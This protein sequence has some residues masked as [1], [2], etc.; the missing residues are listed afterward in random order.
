M[1]SRM[2]SSAVMRLR[3]LALDPAPNPD[4]TRIRQEQE[5]IA[6]RLALLDLDLGT[7]KEARHVDT[8]HRHHA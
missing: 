1:I 7:V 4:L 2:V 5:L 3:S 6:R 8:R